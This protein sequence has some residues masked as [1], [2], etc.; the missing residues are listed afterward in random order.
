M[1][2]S[3]DGGEEDDEA[4]AFE[5]SI[6]GTRPLRGAR[7]APGG[8]P[9]GR[10][11][12]VKPQ[13]RPPPFEVEETPDQIRGRRRDVPR[14]VL[15]ALRAGQPPVDA[16]LDLHGRTADDAARGVERFVEAARA[17]GARALLVIHGRGRNSE[18]GGPVLRPAIWRWLA[19]AASAQA[20]VLAFTSASPRDGADGATI[21]LLQ[22]TRATSEP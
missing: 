11:A 8:A 3:S 1:G 13:G 7:R 2:A 16:R 18:V 21:I 4:R 20:G 12:V 19:S 9:A 10:P 22:R 5:E 17:R 15:R 14:E 6:R